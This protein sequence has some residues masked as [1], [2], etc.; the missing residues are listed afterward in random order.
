MT[1]TAAESFLHCQCAASGKA[2]H[3]Q[4]AFG[5][6][7]GRPVPFRRPTACADDSS[8]AAAGASCGQRTSL[9]RLDVRW[10]ERIWLAHDWWLS[11]AITGK[12]RSSRSKEAL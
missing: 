5:R 8:E 2:V 1:T 3:L 12:H 11:F 6:R 10:P 4:L 7:G 9:T